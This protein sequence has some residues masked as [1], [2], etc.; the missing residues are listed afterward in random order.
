MATKRRRSRASRSGRRRR[1]GNAQPPRKFI[2]YYMEEG[3]R[4]TDDGEIPI[5]VDEY[6]REEGI[7]AADLAVKALKDAGA[8]E[9]S[10]T[11]FAPRV[12]YTAYH[13]QDMH[14]GGYPTTS[15]FPKGFSQD[16]LKAIYDGVTQRQRRRA[17]FRRASRRR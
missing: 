4:K 8:T 12:W 7:T 1:S 11:F 15:Y 16:E 14:T 13:G 9:P 17:S 3:E 6:D 10:S 2:K 5:E